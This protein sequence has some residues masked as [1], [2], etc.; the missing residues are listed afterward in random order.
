MYWSVSLLRPFL[1]LG[2]PITF[3]VLWGG[4]YTFW[5]IVCLAGFLPLLVVLFG[6]GC[7]K[8]IL[9]RCYSLKNVYNYMF[10]LIFTLLTP[11]PSML[12]KQHS[13]EEYSFYFLHFE[14]L[15][16]IVLG[17]LSFQPSYLALLFY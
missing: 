5:P 9:L 16:V 7:L 8:P 13:I 14:L 17:A 3:F 11:S 6:L 1:L 10:F 4:P 15:V 2:W 12:L